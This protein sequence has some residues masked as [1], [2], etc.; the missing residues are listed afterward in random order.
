M[1]LT[2][3]LHLQ[4]P[5]MCY[6]KKQRCREHFS[7]Q[8]QLAPGWAEVG[9][10]PGEQTTTKHE[11]GTRFTNQFDGGEVKNRKNKSDMEKSMGQSKRRKRGSGH[12]DQACFLLLP[13]R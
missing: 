5:I 13:A 12:S 10:S 1:K 9:H 8:G 2:E 6:K 4:A 7:P 3:I 11:T